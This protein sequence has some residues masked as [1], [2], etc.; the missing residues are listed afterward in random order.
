MR[1]VAKDPDYERR[2][3]D[4]FARQ[5]LMSTMGVDMVEL[6]PGTCTLAMDHRRDLCQQ[7]GYHH[8]GVTTA[9]ADSAAGYAAY[10]LMP[11]G[12]SVLTVEYKI[13][14]MAPAA[15]ERFLARAAVERAGRTITVVRSEVFAVK[16]GEEKAIAFM[17]AT[18]MCLADTPDS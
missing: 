18:M 1:F 13:N 6:A 17:L 7:H 5:T 12:S 15:G 3:R 4:S 9:L 11:P 16:G 2:V 10:S 14:L 8:A